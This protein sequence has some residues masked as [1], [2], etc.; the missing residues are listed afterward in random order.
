MKPC[1]YVTSGW[2]IHDDRWI[3][4]LRSQGYEP[5]VIRLSVDVPDVGAL[6]SAVIDVA[7]PAVP[8]I[9]GPLETIT[10]PLTGI[11]APLIGLSWGFDLHDMTDSGWLTELDGIIVDSTATAALAQAA[12]VAPD[13]ITFLPWG[14]DLDT[15]QPQGPMHDFTELGIPAEARIVLSLRAHEPRYRVMD[16]IE[17][18][19]KISSTFL[20]AYLIIGNAGSLTPQLVEATKQLGITDR[21][22]FIGMIPEASLAKSLRSTHAYVTTSEVDGT[23]VTL[24][25]AMACGTPVIAS[26]TPGN[27]YWIDNG[28]S[29]LMYPTGDTTAL[30]EQLARALTMSTESRVRMVEMARQR[31]LAEADWNRNLSALDTAL[32]VARSRRMTPQG[33]PDL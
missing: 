3:S 23:S 17:S 28:N 11:A 14:V 5:H 7:G 8:V 15:F 9:A 4:A 32:E 30:A 12:G 19:A 13:R 20:D 2:G 26:A 10:K 21:V 29:G 31:V 33:D 25:Q 27:L 22:R 16:A 6:R 1:V 18:F 24:L